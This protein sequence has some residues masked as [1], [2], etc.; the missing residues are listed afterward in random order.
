MNLVSMTLLATSLSVV[1]WFQ[2]P[3][4]ARKVM[5]SIPV[6][7]S[8]FFSLSWQLTIPTFLRPFRPEKRQVSL[9]HSAY[10]RL[11]CVWNRQGKVSTKL[12]LNQIRRAAMKTP[13]LCRKSPKTWMNAALTFTFSSSSTIMKLEGEAWGVLNSVFFWWPPKPW[14]CP[15][16][17]WW[18]IAPNL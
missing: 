4:G 16:P 15:W 3:S 8:D 11:S 2:R 10:I 9:S 14:L 6:G 18:S 12:T 5:H 7:D 17:F 13:T 1:Q